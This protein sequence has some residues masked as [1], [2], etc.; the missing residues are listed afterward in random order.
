MKSVFRFFFC[1]V[2]LLHCSGISVALP[3]CC[4]PACHVIE[5]DLCCSDSDQDTEDCCDDQTLS[6]SQVDP[7]ISS[8][9]KY[10]S[11]VQKLQI[12]LVQNFLPLNI[13]AE[14]VPPKGKASSG[15][16]PKKTSAIFLKNC[17]L[18]I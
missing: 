16:P 2:I 6:Y 10:N 3:A 11:E 1:F 12:L 15:N 14:A 17:I 7:F 5:E 18:L 8:A 4:A 9:N 13:P